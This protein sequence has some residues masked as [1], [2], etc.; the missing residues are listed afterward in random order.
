MNKFSKILILFVCGFAT[1]S[2]M[3]LSIPSGLTG[4]EPDPSLSGSAG[5]GPAVRGL[6]E[7]KAKG[8]D[9][10]RP[11]A[12]ELENKSHCAELKEGDSI[13]KKLL[14]R[15]EYTSDQDVNKMFRGFD[16]VV[17]HIGKAPPV[18]QGRFLNWLSPNYAGGEWL[19]S[20]LLI[21]FNGKNEL[22]NVV[23]KKWAN[24]MI[25][26]AIKTLAPHK[27][28]SR[29][30]FEYF[31]KASRIFELVDLIPELTEIVTLGKDSEEI[32]KKIKPE[33]LDSLYKQL[34]HQDFIHCYKAIMGVIRQVQKIINNIDLK[35]FAPIDN[36]NS[37]NNRK[38]DSLSKISSKLDFDFQIF[39]HSILSKN[40]QLKQKLTIDLFFRF[41][42]MIIA[43]FNGERVGDEVLSDI[44]KLF[45]IPLTELKQLDRDFGL[46][47]TIFAEKISKHLPEIK[48]IL[49]LVKSNYEGL[50]GQN[51]DFRIKLENKIEPTVAKIN[52]MV[53]IDCDELF[54]LLIKK[55]KYEGFSNID[56][57][58]LHSYT[59][60]VLLDWNL[61]LNLVRSQDEKIKYM[62]LILMHPRQNFDKALKQQIM[63]VNQFAIDCVQQEKE[64]Y[65]KLLFYEIENDGNY[66]LI[67]YL[68]DKLGENVKDPK[69]NTALNLAV[70]VNKLD[71]V[72]ML[73]DRDA[74]NIVANDQPGGIE[75][76]MPLLLTEPDDAGNGPIDNALRL[77]GMGKPEIFKLFMELAQH[78]QDIPV[79]A[80]VAAERVNYD[81]AKSA[82]PGDSLVMAPEVY[83]VAS[84]AEL[85]APRTR[86]TNFCS[87]CAI[88]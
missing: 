23:L 25:G 68:L 6:P 4:L 85:A 41:L 74:Q 44:L 86:N 3:D 82:G 16:E 22:L 28:I 51:I 67:N 87:R 5:P 38:L 9:E 31:L 17:K 26:I 35:M 30:I 29:E 55:I 11:G 19:R 48:K 77:H 49:A 15:L 61:A 70:R 62:K 20:L 18:N 46:L 39:F 40:T 34:N 47:P 32:I 84:E 66:N 71:V 79:V 75:N 83:E 72:K 78:R 60:N 1:V 76:E 59:C 12:S 73:L 13:L 27:P 69:G 14:E 57:G 10:N 36:S 33:Y 81:D 64:K 42:Y 88:L 7:Q 24:S 45:D 37:L 65:L 53:S 56:M 52:A 21:L 43:S 8:D 54:N 50:A 58:I 80:A 2:A 63:F